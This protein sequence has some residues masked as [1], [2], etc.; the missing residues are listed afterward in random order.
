MKLCTI[1]KRTIVAKTFVAL[2][3]KKN[4]QLGRMCLLKN[5]KIAAVAN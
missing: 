3:K 5:L 2:E 4:F 1:A